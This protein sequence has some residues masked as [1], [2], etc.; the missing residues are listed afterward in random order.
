MSQASEEQIEKEAKGAK[1]A[2]GKGA[3]IKY[4]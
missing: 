3:G 1:V 2:S 4:C